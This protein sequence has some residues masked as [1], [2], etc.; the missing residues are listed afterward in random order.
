MPD[1]P[2]TIE[3]ESDPAIWAEAAARHQM[4]ERN[5]AWLESNTAEV[6]SRRG[7]F[8]CIAGQGLFVG[9]SV[10]DVIRAAT[11]A[12][13]KDEGRFTRY[14]PLENIPRIYAHARKRRAVRRVSFLK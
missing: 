1:N 8:I 10:E 6:Y 11:A 2:I 3:T 4:F 14:I 13:P 5:W 9:D 12:H 7:K